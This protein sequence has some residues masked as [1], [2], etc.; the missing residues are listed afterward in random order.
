MFCCVG[1]LAADVDAT[2]ELLDL[3]GGVEGDLRAT[4]SGMTPSLTKCILER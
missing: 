4:G 2:E 3:L 1:L